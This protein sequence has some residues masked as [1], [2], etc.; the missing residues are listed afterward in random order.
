MSNELHSAESS[1]LILSIDQQAA[2]GRYMI[3]LFGRFI[4]PAGDIFI[5]QS[6]ISSST[7]GDIFGLDQS[8]S[9]ALILILVLPHIVRNIFVHL[10]RINIYDH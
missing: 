7:T 4:F 8:F 1:P 9:H 5:C 3:Y 2:F 6:Y 10:L